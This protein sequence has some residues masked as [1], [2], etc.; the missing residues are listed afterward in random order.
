MDFLVYTDEPGDSSNYI[1]IYSFLFD[2]SKK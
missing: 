2:L 1:T